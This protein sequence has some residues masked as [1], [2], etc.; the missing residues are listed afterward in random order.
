MYFF[1]YSIEYSFNTNSRIIGKIGSV[2][3]TGL[4]KTHGV[5]ETTFTDIKR[6]K[7]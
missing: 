1:L 7:R 4:A 5:G 6:T 3:V 2:N